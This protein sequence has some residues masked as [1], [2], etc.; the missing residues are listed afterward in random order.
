MDE[1][2]NE[3]AAKFEQAEIYICLLAGI[4]RQS[5]EMLMEIVSEKQRQGFKKF[6]ILIHSQG[7][8]IQSAVTGYNFL[9]GFRDLEIVTWNIGAV[10]SSA[11]ALYCAGNIRLIT[12]YAYFFLHDVFRKT[13]NRVVVK[14][15]EFMMLYNDLLNERKQYAAIL[16]K[17]TGWSIEQVERAMKKVTPL[18]AEEAVV[19]GLAH[20]VFEKFIDF[21]NEV[22]FIKEEPREGKKDE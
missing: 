12:P 16:K 13:N 20:D 21:G 17:A 3:T 14:E 4:N 15:K 8:D 2:Q 1:E 18:T 9:T 6:V 5:M 22:I 10:E 19:C 7:G 11:V